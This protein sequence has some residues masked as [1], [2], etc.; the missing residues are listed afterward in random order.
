MKFS[1]I[2]KAIQASRQGPDGDFEKL[3]IDS[4]Q[5]KAGD[6]FIAIK[7]ER[8]DGTMFIEQAILQGAKAIIAPRGPM[9]EL[10][11]SVCFMQVEDTTIALGRLASFW[12]DKC[13]ISMIGVT[14]SCGK[15]SV[16]GMINTIC[17]IAGKT[18]ATEGNFNNHIGLP[19]TLLRLDNT[20]RYAVIEMGASAKGEIAYLGQIAKPTVTQILMRLMPPKWLVRLNNETL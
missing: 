7:G 16:K 9:N 13:A 14:G 18:L 11:Q 5:V 1:Q 15:T 17:Q 12:R 20:Y 19:L 3:V 10:E 6:C 8:L 4:R 2:A